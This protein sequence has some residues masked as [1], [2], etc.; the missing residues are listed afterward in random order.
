[1]AAIDLLISDRALG[2]QTRLWICTFAN[3]QFGENFGE[4]I[5]DCPFAQVIRRAASSTILIVDREAGSLERTWCGLEMYYTEVQE[6]DLT[7]YTS[8]GEV[9]SKCASSGPL[10]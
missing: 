2:S 8:V 3:T 9:G 10:V 5:V 6:K 4:H 1:M 7:L